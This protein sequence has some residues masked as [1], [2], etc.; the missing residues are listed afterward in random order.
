MSR[1]IVLSQCALRLFL[2]SIRDSWLAFC[3]GMLFLMVCSA[4]AIAQ[5]DLANDAIKN[6]EFSIAADMANTATRSQAD[7]I[8]QNLAAAQMQTG[9][10][11]AMANSLTRISSDEQ[12]SRTANDLYR[13]MRQQIDGNAGGITMNDFRPLI[14]LIE[15]TIAPDDWSATQGEGTIQPY[16]SGV[17]VDASGVLHRFQ[18]DKSD[19]LDSMLTKTH[20][21]TF[22]SQSNLRTLSLLQLERE[23]MSCALRHEPLPLELKFMAGIYDLQYLIV[24]VE[25]RD[26]LIAGPAGPWQI[27]DEGVAVNT[28]TGRPVLQVDDFVN[29]LRS[30]F[31][32]EGRFGCSITPRQENLAAT[33][34]FL[35]TS[36]LNG[37]QWRAELQKSLGMQD[38]EVFG[39]PDQSTSARIL[40]EADY[41]MKLLG[42]GIE[43]TRAKVPSYLDRAA[44]SLG[45]NPLPLDVARWWF[46]LDYDGISTNKSRTVFEF[47]GTGVK[48][49]SET[50]LL[51]AQGNR[52]HTGNA[53]GPTK[54]FAEDFTKNFEELALEY[55]IYNQLRNVFDFAIVC[56]VIKREGFD[57]QVGWQ[58]SYFG[59]AHKPG[60]LVF[61]IESVGV[62]KEVVSVMNHKT[63]TVR[64]GQKRIMHSLV[65]V[66]GGIDCPA[67]KWVNEIQFERVNSS[68][69][70]Q[71][72]KQTNEANKRELFRD[73]RGD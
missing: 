41:R 14:S 49:L 27:S 10:H 57:K 21:G 13:G 9:S 72:V 7:T 44:E 6:G 22:M 31:F 25:N 53:V 51:D 66:S 65:G 59:V 67:S 37:K 55:P 24:D 60:D 56:S 38:I 15:S 16:L 61:P 4:G 12:Y 73:I 40:V 18:P 58:M 69:I 29:C 11:E 3:L 39:L 1:S 19:S 64:N 54:Q 70:N 5:T 20:A 2:W 47:N 46:T 43:T 52:I 23:S 35:E 50:E 36:K 62:A 8:W 26:I 63:K 28:E 33:Q 71:L 48:V 17:F 68:S 34:Q 32:G 42:M 45:E 30:V